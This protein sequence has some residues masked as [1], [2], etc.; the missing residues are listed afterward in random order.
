MC[1]FESTLNLKVIPSTHPH[2]KQHVSHWIIEVSGPPKRT[3]LPLITSEVP[4]LCQLSGTTTTGHHH[5]H[6]GISHCGFLVPAVFFFANF[7]WLNVKKEVLFGAKNRFFGGWGFFEEI[8]DTHNR[9]GLVGSSVW[10]CLAIKSWKYMKYEVCHWISYWIY[11][12]TRPQTDS[13][14]IRLFAP[15]E[16]V[17]FMVVFIPAFLVYVC[18]CPDLLEYHGFKKKTE[19]I[20]K[21]DG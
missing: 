19:K 16:I 4:V 2:K 3:L 21:V 13:S 5:Q 18:L 12:P 15:E 1:S 14:R 9:K 10:F 17:H 6:L 8:H 11:Q 7:W 20:Q